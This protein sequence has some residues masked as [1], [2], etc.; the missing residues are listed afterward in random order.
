MD[1]SGQRSSLIHTPVSYLTYL[2]V[3]TLLLNKVEAT[4]FPGLRAL[5]IIWVSERVYQAL[6]EKARGLGI[7]VS[8]LV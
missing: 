1:S 4:W 7:V 2:P 8:E 3:H 6:D 5:P